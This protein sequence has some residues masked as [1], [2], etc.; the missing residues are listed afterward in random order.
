[1][2]RLLLT[3]IILLFWLPAYAGMVIGS[4]AVSSGGGSCSAS[5]TMLSTCSPPAYL[6][7]SGNIGQAVS[8]SSSITI[9]QVDVHVYGTSGNVWIEIWPT[10]DKS[11]VQIG[12]D[13]GSTATPTSSHETISCTWS[14]SYPQPTGDFYIHVETDSGTLRVYHCNSATRYLDTDYDGFNNSAD[15]N[16]DIYFVVYTQ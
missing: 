7:K 16:V 5:E 8:N 10:I 11:G 13:S 14:S 4:G 2:K 9:C 6:T 12:G 15:V 3:V 1:M